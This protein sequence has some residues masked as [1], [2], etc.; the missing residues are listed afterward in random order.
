[1]VLVLRALGLGDLLTVVPALRGLRRAYPGHRVVLAAPS[2]LG[3]L[4]P[5]IGAVDEVLDVGGPGPVPYERPEVAVNLHG[6]GPQS[7][8]ALSRTRPGRL[9][10]HAHPDHPGVAGPAWD[11]GA[12]EVHRWCALL[13]WYGIAADPGDLA[14]RPPGG[15][16]A[17]EEP[18]V[19]HPGAAAGARRWPAERF[20][21]VASA[22]GR[23]GRRVVVTGSA[24]EAA[25]ARRVAALAGLPA[26]RV[27]AGRTGLVELAV[28]VGGAR[29]VICGDTGV[30]HLA[31]ALGT[32][33]VVIFGPV[34]PALWGPPPGLGRH[35]ALW[36][37]RTGDPHGD[38]PD[39]G[40]LEIGVREVLGAARELLDVSSPG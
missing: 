2:S 4:V 11:G 5:L 7:T 18:V 39:P 9:L 30:A 34:S 3:A 6:R 21:G 29:L 23:A 16:R 12:H 25:T 38:R 22:L 8:R 17:G 27:L 33:S 31:T 28:L 40:L 24:A 26:A 13:E 20:A 36:A 15:G 1:V 37:G 19:V 35:I 32:P 10:A 14:L